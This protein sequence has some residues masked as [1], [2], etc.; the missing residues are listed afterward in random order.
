MN[1]RATTARRQVAQIR[2][3]QEASGLGMLGD[4]EAAESRLESYLRAANSDLERGDAV[5]A[6]QDLNS[7]EPEL[8]TLERVLGH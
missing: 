4:V 7:A 5:A 2:R 6:K 3:E 8:K 1:A